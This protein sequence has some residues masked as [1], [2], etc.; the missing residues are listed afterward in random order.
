MGYPNNCN[1][2]AKD[3]VNADLF[4]GT[5]ELT[6]RPFKG[7]DPIVF[8]VG[9]DPTVTKREINTVLDLE[10]SD[11]LLSKYLVG[12]ILTPAGLKL[13][14]VYA[15]DLIKCRFPHNQTPRSIAKKHGIKMVEYLKPFFQNCRKWFLEE[16]QEMKPKILVSLGEPVHQLLVEDFAWNVP[17]SMKDAFGYTYTVKL[18]D[19]YIYYV[20]C[21]HINTK[22][23]EY[24]KT[25]WNTF[26]QS[27]S[28][29][30]KIAGNRI[31][32]GEVE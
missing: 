26:L 5:P 25:H 20:P 12:K 4:E 30:V 6:T 19:K 27:F 31:Q 24:Y 32:L 21:I 13:D 1:V 9:Q 14:D 28:A 16:V 18:L 11:G 7:T 23:H 2:C 22:R 8:L 29:T 3:K 15:T 10:N 17:K